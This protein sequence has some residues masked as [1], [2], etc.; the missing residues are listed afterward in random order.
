MVMEISQ[1][2]TTITTPFIVEHLPMKSQRSQH[3]AHKT[4]KKASIKKLNRYIDKEV[5]LIHENLEELKSFLGEHA[6]MPDENV[7]HADARDIDD[8]FDSASDL[9]RQIALESGSDAPLDTKIYETLL[10]K[11]KDKDRRLPDR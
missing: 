10:L 11:K 7:L 4:G 1:R 9:F 5:T 3:P 6:S 8:Y 2:K